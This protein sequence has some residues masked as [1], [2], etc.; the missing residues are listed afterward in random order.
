MLC[1]I[2]IVLFFTFNA[3]ANL[4]FALVYFQRI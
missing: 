3:L 1:Y 4:E 2:F